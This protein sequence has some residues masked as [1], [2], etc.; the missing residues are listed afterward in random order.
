MTPRLP[1]STM[2]AWRR[3]F[4]AARLRGGALAADRT[5]SPLNR[6]AL[7][8]T[9]PRVTTMPPQPTVLKALPAAFAQDSPRKS[10]SLAELSAVYADKRGRFIL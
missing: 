8:N 6:P 10:A 4:P 1:L 5:P 9:V 7:R 3:R 2:P